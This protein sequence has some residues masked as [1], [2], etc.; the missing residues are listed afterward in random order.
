MKDDDHLVTFGSSGPFAGLA[1]IKFSPN[2]VL[3]DKSFQ[4][5]GGGMNGNTSTLAQ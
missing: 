1:G 4:S 3:D 2:R 5:G